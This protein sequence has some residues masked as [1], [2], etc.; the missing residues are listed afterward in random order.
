MFRHFH[1]NAAHSDACTGPT[2]NL[3]RS[4]VVIIQEHLPHY[5][6]AFYNQLHSILASHNVDCVLV[7]DPNTASNLI[8]G[9]CDWANPIPV[10]W[11]GPIGWQP[12]LSMTK[13]ADLVVVQQESKYL[14]NYLLLL[15]RLLSRAK[16]AFWGHGRNMQA[17]NTKSWPERVKRFISTRVDWWFAYNETSAAVVRDLGF[18]KD[19][20]TLV[21]NSI[22]TKAIAAARCSLSLRAIESAKASLG[23]ESS[24]VAIF[25]GGLYDEKRIPF[26][27]EAAA[28][29]RAQLPDF[30]LIII[31]GGP[32]ANLV[33]NTADS[34]P[35]IHYLGPMNDEEKIPYWA[36]AKVSLLP[37]LVGLGVLDSLALGVPLITTAYPFHSPEIEYL[38]EGVNGVIVH[39]WTNIDAYARAV[40]D[41]LRDKARLAH[42]IAEGDRAIQFYTIE[43]MA[44]NFSNGILKALQL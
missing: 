24:N 1:S 35:W 16:L 29:V 22:D 43:N 23:I 27:L 6:V 4:R 9:H 40:V 7:Y 28:K 39:E 38:H 36:M 32:L 5:R 12:A 3:R 44:A 10:K 18:P 15:N 34:S 37:G 42:M 17:R 14:L 30:H 41:L 33:Q 8:K 2:T 13:N 11:F 26:L 31:G 21:N 19:R 20:I 25:T